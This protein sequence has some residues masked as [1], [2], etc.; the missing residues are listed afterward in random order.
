MRCIQ[1]ESS[2]VWVIDR[3]NFGLTCSQFDDSSLTESMTCNE[4]KVRKELNWLAEP[5]FSSSRW[6]SNPFH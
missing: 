5:T 6:L 2:A 3:V 1:I 4:F